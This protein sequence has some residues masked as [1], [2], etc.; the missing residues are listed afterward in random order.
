MQHAKE[1]DFVTWA[2]KALC[3]HSHSWRCKA[4]T[5][6]KDAASACLCA[7][8]LCFVSPLYENGNNDVYHSVYLECALMITNGLILKGRR[9]SEVKFKELSADGI[10]LLFSQVVKI[11]WE[12]IW[13]LWF[14]LGPQ[15]LEYCP[16]PNDLLT[17]SR[18]IC[19]G[20]MRINICEESFRIPGIKFSSSF[21][22]VC[23]RVSLWSKA[24]ATHLLAE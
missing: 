22:S 24:L 12:K 14:G 6:L 17:I 10:S 4:W 7:L 8:S 15:G 11:S 19:E 9:F 18:I 1:V 20:T 2:F 13:L 16:Y 23:P 3:C 5:L 21:P